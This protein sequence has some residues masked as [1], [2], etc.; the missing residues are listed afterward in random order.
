[1]CSSDLL[2]FCTYLGGSNNEQPHSM[3]T[4]SLDN[5]YVMGSTRSTDFPMG[6]SGQYDNS[7][8]GSYDFFITKF[9]STG[10]KILASTYF[11]GS[12]MDAVGADR[13]ATGVSVDDFPL[14][15]NYADEFRGEIITDQKNIYLSG[16]TYSMNFPR[17]GNGV[18]GGKSDAVVFC[19]NNSLTTL[20]WSQQ[21]GGVSYDALYGVALGKSNDVYVSG[22]SSSNN[23]RTVVGSKW[24][25]DYQGG[26][27]DAI[28]M[29][30]D[31]YTGDVIQGR[32][33][34][35]SLYEQAHFV[36][37]GLTGKPYIYGQ[38]EANMPNVNARFFQPGGG[39]YISCYSVDLSTVDMQTTF[40]YNPSNV[41]NPNI[42]PS[43]FLVDRCERIF[44]SGWGG[45]TNEIG[46]AHV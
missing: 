16:I 40:G 38:T 36:Q 8:N 2:L 9:N 29:R 26:I 11:G 42:S 37:T 24:I 33:H 44:V 43:A 31:K 41:I 35:T 14:I 21:F 20:K 32:Y 3:V 34:G 25:N 28:L 5:L 10:T 27:A 13:S 18:Y 19:L 46:R 4:D 23:L 7:H 22:G 12:G 17:T 30:L 39:Q 6:S 1:M 45:S 15:Y